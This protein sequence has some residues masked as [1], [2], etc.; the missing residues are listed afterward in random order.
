MANKPKLTADEWA[1][2]RTVWEADTRK[3][4]D[5]LV[6]E[7][8]LG[9]SRQAVSKAAK[10]QGWFKGMEN[11]DGNVA[12]PIIK[13]CATNESKVT[14][15]KGVGVKA[16]NINDSGKNSNVIKST[17][18]GARLGAGA[19]PGLKL[20]MKERAATFGEDAITIM[21]EIMNDIGVQSQVRLAACDKLLDRGFGKPKQ[22]M[23][24]SG[25]LKYVDKNDLEARYAK[26]MEKTIEYARIAA[27]RRKIIEGVKVH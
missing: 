13:S 10:A 18:G 12:Q 4:F 15:L 14:Q 22:E 24:V 26:N 23:E 7:L 27:E 2:A 17:H 20:T 25:E 8:K 11:N 21:S 6:L 3:G 1:N 16:N 9:I 19:P 5:W